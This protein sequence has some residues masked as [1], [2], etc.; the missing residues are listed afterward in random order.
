MRKSMLM[1][2]MVAAGLLFGVWQALSG[3]DREINRTGGTAMNHTEK[4]ETAVFAG[5]CF[6]CTESDFEKI[7]GVIAA[8][9]GYTGGHVD[10]PT[11][12]Q[13]SDG[14]TGHVESVKVTYDPGKITYWELLT[15][16]WRLIDPTDAGGQFVDRGDQY[17][18]VIFYADDTQ[19]KLA[20]AS[21]KQLGETG[22]F[23][24]P[25]VTDILPLGPFYPAETYHQDYYREK[26]FR[27]KWYRGGSGRDKFLEAFWRDKTLLLPLPAALK[28]PAAG[29]APKGGRGETAGVKTAD[30]EYRIP[31][32]GRLREMLTPLQYKV[33]REEGTE[34]AFDN[35][36]WDNHAPGIYV[37]IV[38]GEPLFSSR[39]KFASGTGWPS[40][41][42][43]LVPGNIVERADTGFFMVRTEV[44]SKHADAHLG[45]VFKD[46][47]APTYL[48]YC[49][50][51]A[52]LRFVPAEDLEKEGYGQFAPA[53]QEALSD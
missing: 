4:T 11:Y 20:E 40:F 52:A 41:T 25:I 22:I 14:G 31:T 16:F 17:R 46:G 9:S 35:A 43:P 34:P 8:V 28:G 15:H 21:K 29:G 23:K 3:A 50:N 6:W 45:H 49:I 51:S 48:R 32:D 19:R 30:G 42:Q 53:F 27:Y 12:G 24:Q 37:D 10:N 26:P 39:D 5:G 7:E 13:V 1:M 33:V 36:Y 38:S 47:P 18:S 2:A 44:R